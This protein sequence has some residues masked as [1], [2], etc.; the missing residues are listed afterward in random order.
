M[1]IGKEPMKRRGYKSKAEQQD[2]WQKGISL[3]A[4][5]TLGASE[6]VTQWITQTLLQQISQVS[7]YYNP[8]LRKY[9]VSQQSYC[10]V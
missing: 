5:P 9:W 10:T 4:D 1:N 8:R 3:W 6:P 2:M 7:T